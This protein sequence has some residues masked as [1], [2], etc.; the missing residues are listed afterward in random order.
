MLQQSPKIVPALVIATD[1]ARTLVYFSA[2]LAVGITIVGTFTEISSFIAD[3]STRMAGAFHLFGAHNNF[4]GWYQATAFSLV[5][6]LWFCLSANVGGER[7][8][9]F[10][11]GSA[12]MIYMSAGELTNWDHPNFARLANFIAPAESSHYV[13]STFGVAA[14]LC[15]AL[16]FRF[17]FAS[18]T[19]FLLALIVYSTGAF[20]FELLSTESAIRYGTGA[21]YIG[22]SSL[23]EVFEMAGCFM[24]FVA[25]VRLAIPPSHLS[26]LS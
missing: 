8:V 24:L 18:R 3:P 13:L 26:Q 9:G 5:A 22:V 6:M 4:T 7:K 11:A 25:T 12:A 16:W 15:M 1:L 2:A 21:I 23:E 14:A 20:G 17:M 10:V 19:L